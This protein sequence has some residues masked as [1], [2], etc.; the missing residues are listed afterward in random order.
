MRPAPSL[1]RIPEF[2][3]VTVISAMAIFLTIAI[4]AGRTSIDPFTMTSLA[5]EGE[6]W[7][8]AS[9]ALPHGDWLH[10]AFNIIWLWILGTRFEELLGHVTT[11][12]IMLVLAIGSGAAEYTFAVGGIGLS[13]VGYGLVGALWI[14]RWRD[15][16]FRDAIDRNVMILFI[17][18]GLLCVLL[19]VTNIWRIGNIAHGSGFVLGMLIGWA[20]APGKVSRRAGAG[21]VLVL[22]VGAL[23][24]AAGWLRPQLNLA[25]GAADEDSYRGAEAL[26]ERKYELAA[27]HLRRAIELAPGNA[28]AWYNYGVAL[29]HVA[30]PQ[31]LTSRQAWRRAYALEPGDSQIKGAAARDRLR[32]AYEAQL[33]GTLPLALELYRQSIEIQETASAQWNRGTA[34]QALGNSD[35]AQRAFARARELDP[36]I[37]RNAGV[38]AE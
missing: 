25:G 3:V 7:R 12:A 27:R 19:T 33:G 4:K 15:N 34:L 32:E 9:S 28:D 37:E 38:I 22:I 11:F 16:R 8:L 14:L 6:P 18:W 21:A 5:F 36:A 31:G 20:L 13:G 26:G 1:L 35:E 29:Q 24:G 23:V 30:D 2:P 10:L 17:A